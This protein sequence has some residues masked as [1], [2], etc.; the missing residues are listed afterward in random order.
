MA[1]MIQ[2]A[3]DAI[4]GHQWGNSGVGGYHDYIDI[5]SFIDWQI[6]TEMTSNFE[7][8]VLNGQYMHFDPRIGNNG[9]L[10]MGPIWDLDK[11]WG[12]TSTGGGWWQPPGW[13]SSSQAAAGFVR[14]SPFWYKELLGWEITGTSTTDIFN[15]PGRD[16]SD[17][18]DPYYTQ[19]L[20]ARWNEVKGE[21]IDKLGPYIDAQ[22]T[23]LSRIA[24]YSSVNY[25]QT[26]Q[27]ST[28]LRTTIT[29]RVNAL[30][31]VINGY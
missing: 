21:F 17:R 7:L 1:E 26:V 27:P 22:N 14:K 29:N 30:D 13:G 8:S 25:Q 28:A 18:K 3:E 5:D 24:T 19:R 12:E 9:K 15:H 16:S 23:R 2:N 11:A 20:K 4:Y 31:T 6:A 10:K